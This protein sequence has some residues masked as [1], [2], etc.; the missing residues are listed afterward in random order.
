MGQHYCDV[1]ILVNY[2]I[3][4][5]LFR[6][7]GYISTRVI[8][9]TGLLEGACSGSHSLMVLE[10]TASA[11]LPL[12]SLHRMLVI[13]LWTGV[14]LPA[15]PCLCTPSVQYASLITGAPILL[16]LANLLH[17]GLSNDMY[18]APIT[19]IHAHI[20][21][22]NPSSIG[23]I[24]EPLGLHF[25]SVFQIHWYSPSQQLIATVIYQAR[26]DYL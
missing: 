6:T 9:M 1:L 21:Y 15:L 11:S 5:G 2:T 20:P 17:S 25:V 16:T 4:L 10:C 7:V 13:L 26:K 24:D 18:H 19:L 8:T 22:L 23:S 3:L 12:P 14:C